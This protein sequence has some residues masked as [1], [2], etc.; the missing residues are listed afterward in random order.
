[1]KKLIM[2]GAVVAAGYGL[3]LLTGAN[4]TTFVAF[5]LFGAVSGVLVIKS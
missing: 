5:A 1:M 4:P 3:M 2:M